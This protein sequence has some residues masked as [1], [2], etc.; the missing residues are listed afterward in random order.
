M[1]I[2]L[3]HVLQNKEANSKMTDYS[4]IIYLQEHTM[5]LQYI[6]S[7]VI[8][9]APIVPYMQQMRQTQ[10][11]RYSGGFSPYVSMIL[12]FANIMRLFFW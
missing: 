2:I 8:A 5:V 1:Q 7:F 4:I 11:L 9:V 6:G 12:L 10:Q 3:F